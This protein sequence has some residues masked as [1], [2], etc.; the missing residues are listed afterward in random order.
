MDPNRINLAG[1]SQFTTR[2]HAPAP[3]V[4]HATYSRDPS[5]P[6]RG[7]G[8][9]ESASLAGRLSAETLAALADESSGARGH[10]LPVSTGGQDPTVEQLRTDIRKLKGAGRPR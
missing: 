1:P 4:I 5:R 7:V 3:A 2:P 6:S 10:L 9:I 8:P